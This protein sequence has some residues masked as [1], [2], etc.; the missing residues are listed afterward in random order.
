MNIIRFIVRLLMIVGALNWGLVALGY[1]LVDGI[2]G[3]GSSAARLIYAL[4]GVS[5]VFGLIC[6]CKGCSKSGGSS[7]GCSGSSCGCNKH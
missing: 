3:V 5:G 4:V 6:L 2:F 1:N 7:C